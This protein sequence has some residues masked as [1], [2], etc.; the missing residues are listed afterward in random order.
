MK[1]GAKYAWKTHQGHMRP[2]VAF[3]ISATHCLNA[4]A[5]ARPITHKCHE[6]RPGE[7][8]EGD[9]R[10]IQQIQVT[11]ELN[12]VTE[13]LLGPDDKRR[14]PD[15]WGIRQI[16]QARPRGWNGDMLKVIILKA[17]FVVLPAL[18]IVAKKQISQGEIP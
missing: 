10:R 3:W 4:L 13:T 7:K 14:L 8:N 12:D 15:A 17:H 18:G 5:Q 11:A 6:G 9:S 2:G 1:L 16:S